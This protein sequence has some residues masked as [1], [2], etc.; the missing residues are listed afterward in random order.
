MSSVPKSRRE[1]HDFQADH[2]LR[3]IR[4]R[5]TELAINGFGYDQE[6]F[7]KKI[8]KFE[9]G[10]TDFERKAEVVERWRKKNESYY[11]DFVAEE[12]IETRRII[13]KAVCE[14]ELGN[15]IFPTGEAKLVEFCERRKHFDR[16]IGWLHCLIQELEYIGEILPCDKNAY[17][18]L[19]DAID[20]EIS[21]VK[22]VRRASNKFLKPDNRQNNKKTGR[23]TAKR[24]NS[25]QQGNL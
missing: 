18:N 9:A 5:V 6:R 12:V 21:L 14:F 24:Q 22:G 4:R 25:R 17:E 8:Q 13:R 7:E 19:Q 2:N 16:A 20:L 3:E 23:I 11:K 10:I 15:S 1:K